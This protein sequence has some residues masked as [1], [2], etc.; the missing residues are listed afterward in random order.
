MAQI[1]LLSS[2]LNT[3]DHHCVM[4]MLAPCSWGLILV[5]MQHQPPGTMSPFPEKSG[6]HQSAKDVK[7]QPSIP[8]KAVLTEHKTPL[9][10][11]ANA[12]LGRVERRDAPFCDPLC[13]ASS[14]RHH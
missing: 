4:P 1:F 5:T 2:S 8:S 10:Q 9:G 3:A 12:G 14:I 6:V 11:H 13:N 7:E